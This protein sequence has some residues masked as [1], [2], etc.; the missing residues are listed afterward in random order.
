MGGEPIRIHKNVNKSIG[1][2]RKPILVIYLFTLNLML[3]NYEMILII[4]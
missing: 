3:T 2:K 4:L 1:K